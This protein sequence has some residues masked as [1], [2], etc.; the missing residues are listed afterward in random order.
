MLNVSCDLLTTVVKVK[1]TMVVWGQDV[2]KCSRFDP[3]DR[4]ADWEPPLPSNTREYSM[5]CR[6]PE[7]RSKF[8]G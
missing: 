2:H 4:V 6:R 5:L 1:N 7:K 3:H 8:K